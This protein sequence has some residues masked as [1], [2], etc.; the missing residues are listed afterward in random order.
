MDGVDRIEKFDE[1]IKSIREKLHAVPLVVQFPI[2]VGREL[3]GVVDII[4]QKAHYFKMG[5]RD[6]NYQ[7]KEVPSSLLE[8]TKQYRHE[9]IEK[10]VDH[11]E[12]LAL[13]Y[14]E[15][16]ELTTSEI[17]KLL[18][19]ATL[20]GKYFP[21]FCGSAFKHVGVR[22]LLDGV[23]DYLPSPL[24][25][26]EITVFSPRSGK[27]EGVVNCNSPLSCLALAFKI[28]FDSFNNKLTFIRVYA[29]KLSINSRVYNVNR[30]R[31]E[32]IGRGRLVRVSGDDKEKIEEVGA[33]DIAAVV[34]LE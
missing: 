15:G 24:D 29:G 31:E 10:I 22:L 1:N 27:K 33:G 9:L 4:E 26:P 5:E 16:G 7:T 3:E 8:K 6:E 21:V 14:L 13:K 18:R 23:A 32:G 12:E 17:K 28:T 11:D 25:V 20:S 34:G 19:Q 30:D 2:G